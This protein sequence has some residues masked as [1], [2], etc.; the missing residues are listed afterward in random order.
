MVAAYLEHVA[1][2]DIARA[3]NMRPGHITY[4]FAD[5]E[6]LV[7]ELTAELRALNDGVEIVR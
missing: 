4:Y 6:T 3:L 5:K 2:R 1:V 7:L